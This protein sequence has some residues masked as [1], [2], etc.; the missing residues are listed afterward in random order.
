MPRKM[1]DSGIEWIGEIPEDWRLVKFKR[2][3]KS[4][5]GAT[6]LKENLLPDDSSDDRIPIYSATNTDKVFGYISDSV[7]KLKKNDF[8]IPARGNSIG[9]ITLVRDQIAT[10]TQTTIYSKI[11]NINH[12]FLF[13]CGYGLKDYWFEFDQTAIPQITVK[14]VDN[15]F[16]P[17]PDKIE[18]TRIANYLDRKVAL[19]DSIIEKTKQT[20]EEYK[21]YKQSLI[22]EVVTKGLNKD[23]KMK[24][25]GIEWIGEIP[26]DWEVVNPRRFFTVRR[27]R[28]SINDQQLTSSQKYGIVTQKEFMEIESKRVVVVQ[29]NYAILKKV[30]RNDFIIS[31]RSFQGG[32]ELSG[33]EGSI[34]SAYVV[35][36]PN[37]KIFSKFYKWFFKSVKYIDA[38]Q[39]T[40][41]LVRD[42]Q[43]MRF[44]NFTQ[45]PIVLL[46][47]AVQAFLSEYLENITYRINIIIL[48]KQQLITE[49]E[50]Y[51][52]SLIYE[53]VTGKK[54]V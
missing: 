7:V 44:S 13:Y 47:L 32:L 34:S 27:D 9:Y 25:S 17:V 49:L 38:L 5:M 24:D 37:E 30:L 53:V 50:N 3:A 43:A 22:T 41:N 36:T 51:K 19:I 6:I 54:E 21:A 12:K 40:S 20:I 31:M 29:K 4:G 2:F 52:K 1:K 45:I 23:A 10:C 33:K 42:G 26:E 46:P 39:S 8:V 16:V 11:S 15:N 18:Q 14:Q 35:I 28:A 48:K